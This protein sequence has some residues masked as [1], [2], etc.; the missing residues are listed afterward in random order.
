M[1]DYTALAT[2]GVKGLRIGLLTEGF[3]AAVHDPK[4]SELVRKAASRLEALGAVVSTVSVPMHKN[5]PDLWAVIGRL[6]ASQVAL[7]RSTGRRHLALDD[8]TAKSVPITQESFHDMF[9]SSKNTIVNGEYGWKHMDPTL[10]GKATN[11]VRKLRD[12][13]D[14]AMD[15]VDILLM[16]TL[17]NLPPKHIAEGSELDEVMKNCTGV[18]LNTAPFN[19]VSTLWSV[20]RRGTEVQC[21]CGQAGSEVLAA[22]FRRTSFAPFSE[23][24]TSEAPARCRRDVHVC[25]PKNGQSAV[26]LSESELERE[27]LKA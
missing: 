1:P 14:G 7:G 6:G 27:S 23:C 17:P 13:Y 18:T 22:A 8:F 11:L 9:V 4:V 16:P 20:E 15:E 24:R 2:K 12:A 10:Y 21:D 25:S 19:L 5:G 26:N 3:A